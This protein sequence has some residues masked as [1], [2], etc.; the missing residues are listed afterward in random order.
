MEAHFPLNRVSQGFS[1]AK[2]VCSPS[3]LVGDMLCECRQVVQP[4]LLYLPWQ[5]S[6]AFVCVKGHEPSEWSAIS[7]AGE[8]TDSAAQPDD[9]EILMSHTCSVY[10]QFQP[11]SS[12]ARQVP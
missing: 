2:L 10:P 12:N 8:E 4:T 11:G 1:G 6:R 7:S 5:G 9:K 3:C